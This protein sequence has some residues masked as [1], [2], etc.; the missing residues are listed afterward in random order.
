MILCDEFEKER[1]E[2]PN[3][4]KSQIKTFKDMRRRQSPL[5]FGRLTV[6]RRPNTIM[7]SA[8]RLNSTSMT[9][10]PD[11]NNFRIEMINSAAEA[12]C[13]KSDEEMFEIMPMAKPVDIRLL[14][15]SIGP[16]KEIEF[17][18]YV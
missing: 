15:R 12:S 4:E 5:R 18:D 11:F 1:R 10:E 16:D 13:R 7:E 9:V 2:R 6:Q 17:E 14:N 8:R 3:W